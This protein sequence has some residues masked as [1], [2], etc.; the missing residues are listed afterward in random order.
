[1][2]ASR[3]IFSSDGERRLDS[4]F[5]AARGYLFGNQFLHIWSSP[6]L[7][8]HRLPSSTVPLTLFRHHIM[9]R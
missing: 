9:D 7:Q 6:S 1:M 2:T 8:A 5:L 4:D 3:P